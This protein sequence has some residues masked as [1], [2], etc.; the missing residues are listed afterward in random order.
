MRVLVLDPDRARTIRRKPS[1]RGLD[2][3][4]EVWDGV[5]VM[6]AV[7]NNEHQRIVMSLAGAFMAVV[8]SESGDQVLP[9]ANVSD[10]GEGW[11]KNYRI[12]DVLVILA[13]NPAVDCVTH[14]SGGPGPDLAVEIVSPGDKPR[15]KRK[16]YAK[17]GTKE[18]LIIDRDPWK[19]ELYQLR[20]GVLEPAG[21]SDSARPAVLASTV[22]PLTFQLREGRDRPSILMTHTGTGQTWTA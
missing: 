6:S 3:W 20:D 2:R 19:L 4:D 10:R 22:L 12:P 7:H 1:T 14:W 18:L 5:Y 8:D 16:F 17:V 9:G 21:E 13:G 15:K 11:M